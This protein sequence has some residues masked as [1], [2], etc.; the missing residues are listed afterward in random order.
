MFLTTEN[1][2]AS[3]FENHT[4]SVDIPLEDSAA[5]LA[6]PRYRWVYDKTCICKI[7]NIPHGPSG[8]E[9]KEFP[10]FQKPIQ[11][12]YGMGMGTDIIKN[13]KDFN[14]NYRPGHMWMPV[15]EGRHLSVDVAVVNGQKRY[16]FITEGT[17]GA[18]RRFSHWQYRAP[19][20][21]KY[22]H[23][24]LNIKK[25]ILE[26]VNN[27]LAG[28]T[29]FVNLELIGSTIIEV[30]LRCSPQMI[31]CYGKNFVDA[32]IKLYET[33]EW[34]FKNQMFTDQYIVVAWADSKQNWNIDTEKL[35][36]LQQQHHI[37][38]DYDPSLRS[39]DYYNPPKS[40]RLGYVYTSH[41]EN[42]Y[43]IVKD[44]KSCYTI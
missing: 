15:L 8:V 41:L 2:I 3:L 22:D 31:P 10:V 28:Y 5:W 30:H 42:G 27:H 7:Q 24:F 29:G 44:I 25:I 21:S 37:H 36:K 6:Y 38:L 9:P 14:R 17:P 33:K 26:F 4:T 1:N 35:A 32:L 20:D 43:T 16:C 23:E 34:Q 13:I 39:Y 11:N 12:M 18:Y 40:F 19:I